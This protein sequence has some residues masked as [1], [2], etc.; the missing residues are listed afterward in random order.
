MFPEQNLSPSSSEMRAS[1]FLVK[2]QFL[3]IL[4]V[5]VY[6]CVSLFSSVSTCFNCIRERTERRNKE[7]GVFG[8]VS[9]TFDGKDTSQF[10]FCKS[11]FNS[12]PYHKDFL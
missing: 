1:D 2:K 9:D 10:A 7:T 12:K 8:A 4:V 11:K 3:F 6:A 5:L